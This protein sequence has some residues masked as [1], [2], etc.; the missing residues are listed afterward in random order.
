MI[1]IDFTKSNNEIK[2]QLLTYQAYDISVFYT[3]LED[4]EKKLILNLLGLEK[5]I[6]VF[7][8][9]KYDEQKL[10]FDTL[11]QN[12]QKTFINLLQT[13]ELKEFIFLSE[14]EYKKKLFAYLS[15]E[16]QNLIKKLLTYDEEDAASIM[17]TEYLNV[18]IDMNA[19]EAT[20]YVFKNCK[21]DDFLDIIYV[22]DNDNILLGVVFLKD[23]IIA[24][25]TDKLSDI[26]IKN[27][28][29]CLSNASIREAINEVKAYNV[30]ALPVLDNTDRILGIITADDILEEMYE[31]INETYLKLG[32][33]REH[34]Q[35]DGAFKRAISRTPWSII[36][37]IINVIFLS[38][39]QVFD[40]VI[41]KVGI[42]VLFQSIILDMSGNI[43][44]QALAVTILS[45]G[46][47]KSKK[48]TIK[49]ETLIGALNGFI[50]SV[51]GFV[52]AIAIVYIFKNDFGLAAKPKAYLFKICG[53]FSC[54][55][56][57]A[58]QIGSLIGVLLP[59]ALEKLKLDPAAG[60]GPVLTTINDILSLLLYFGIANLLLL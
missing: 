16:K 12:Q 23:L 47:K 17:T 50:I 15:V 34:K 20:S 28:H 54:S 53:V 45:L 52:F 42:L 59:L 21:D 48:E 1:N 56:F 26:L 44:T 40:E 18:H 51:I 30:N 13:D 37:V 3:T 33:L 49:R 5:M 4:K 27:Y 9:F 39:L 6:K 29:Y 55:L 8:E 2:K 58:M 22:T 57:L 25:K 43:G 19:G 60:A 10:F 41:A 31:D 36:T 7:V 46:D 32:F 11:N 24:R 38:F 14:S 35:E